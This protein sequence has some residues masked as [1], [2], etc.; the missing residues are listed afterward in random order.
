MSLFIILFVL[1]IELVRWCL[2][3]KASAVSDGFMSFTVHDMVM[4]YLKDNIDS[5]QQKQYHKD[6]VE[7]SVTV[8]SVTS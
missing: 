3:Q 5:D 8:V 7:R 4:D 6:V 1:Y 2:A